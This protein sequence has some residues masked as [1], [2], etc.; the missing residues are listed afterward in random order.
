VKNRAA[1]ILDGCGFAL[2]PNLSASRVAEFLAD[3]RR[4]LAA[5]DRALLYHTAAA[6]GF[7]AKGLSRLTPEDFDLTAAVPTATLGHRETKNKGGADQPLPADLVDA[8]RPALAAAGRP[9]RPGR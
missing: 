6:T 8:L 2:I 4:L 9:R 1:R 5:A 7:R 3:L